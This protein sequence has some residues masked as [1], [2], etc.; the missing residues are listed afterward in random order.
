M[1][2]TTVK[3]PTV[4]LVQKNQLARL[5]ATENLTIEHS[6]SAK[7]A[8]FDTNKRKLILPIWNKAS[9][10]L[11]DMLVAHEVG[12]ALITPRD[13]TPRVVCKAMSPTDPN[14]FFCYLNI[15]EDIRVDNEIKDRYPG[16]RR[17]YFNA[18]KELMDRDFFQIAMYGGD[19]SS[20][21][22]GD[23]LNIYSKVGHLG[24]VNVSFDAEEQAIVDEAM[25]VASFDD[26]VAVA[27]KIWNKSKQLQI[28]AAQP[29]PQGAAAYAAPDQDDDDED[30]EKY[31]PASGNGLGNVQSESQDKSNNPSDG[32]TDAKS[33][34]SNNNPSDDNANNGNAGGSHSAPELMTV[35]TLAKNLSGLTS[36]DHYNTYAYYD[37]PRLNLENIIFPYRM[38]IDDLSLMRSH[39]D[40]CGDK[41]FASIQERNKNF[42]SNLVKQFEQKMAADECRR[43][44]TARSGQLDMRKIANYKFSD[45]IFVKNQIVADGKSHGMVFIMDWSGSMANYLLPTVEQLIALIMFCRKM[46]IP[47]E[48]YAFTNV[49]PKRG[50]TIKLCDVP[51]TDDICSHDYTLKHSENG[52]EI[53]TGNFLS[54]QNFGMI[55]F[56]SSKMNTQEFKNAAELFCQ[57]ARN[58]DASNS[59][60][61]KIGDDVRY[62]WSSENR[63]MNNILV[64]YSLHSTP[65]NESIVAAIGIVNR[66]K[67]DNGLDIVN[68]VIL[69]DGEPTGSLCSNLFMGRSKVGNHI[70]N[71]P[72]RKQMAIREVSRLVAIGDAVTAEMCGLAEMFREITGTN[73]ISIRMASS[74][75]AKN[76]ARIWSMCN[77]KE[78]ARMLTEWKEQDFF[79]YR[80]FGFTESF[81]IDTKTEVVDDNFLNINP[82]ASVGTIT[83]A[84][85]KS[86]LK[87]AN[88]R[89]LLS[90]F[91]DLI[92]KKI[93]A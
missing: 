14:K 87:R 88:S 4:N 70:V 75:E 92:A 40:F 74:R 15:V 54:I 50:R 29:D 26:V 45:D 81:V 33:D 32:K 3:N 66:F 27:K 31:S 23:R 73:L 48:V 16:V 85:I 24:F 69:T 77:A 55:Q 83:R 72:N 58:S 65:L 47:F 61:S 41:I 20:L 84:F 12:H 43:T 9:E 93:L 10:D 60:L 8:M 42:V 62:D 13:D 36:D 25:S 18:Y 35:D 11:Y 76:L 28:D 51:N 7:T 17:S 46:N 44:R 34:K 19:L 89:V 82:G 78:E 71:L 39:P 6:A 49:Q 2:T 5:L 91:S 53:E 57:C 21:S 1:T 79:S 68:T 22:F 37:L 64:K 67:A 56:L 80:A 30:E 90:R 52:I 86:N 38:V 59:D 63:M